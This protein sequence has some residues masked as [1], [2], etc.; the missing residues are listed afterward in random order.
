MIFPFFSLRSHVDFFQGGF[1]SKVTF[2]LFRRRMN[3]RIEAA[4][5]T[6]CIKSVHIVLAN[7]SQPGAFV[8]PVQQAAT[9]PT[10]REWEEHSR[11][12]SR[13]GGGKKS[14]HSE[15]FQKVCERT[16]SILNSL[17]WTQLKGSHSQRWLVHW[18]L[19]KGAFKRKLRC[20][21]PSEE[22]H[23]RW[24]LTR[25]VVWERSAA[26][27]RLRRSPETQRSTDF[28]NTSVPLIFTETLNFAVVCKLG[29]IG[30]SVQAADTAAEE[31]QG[32]KETTVRPSA[33]L[34]LTTA[35]SRLLGDFGLLCDTHTL[36]HT[37]IQVTMLKYICV[38]V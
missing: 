2:G 30:G 20:A 32:T 28:K 5:A 10:H 31:W 14:R 17:R 37:H 1:S 35:W 4:T 23:P 6:W 18:G 15:A 11:C 33:P 34:T 26:L 22:T 38:I 13:F 12:E 21:T 3:Q 8:Q 24:F 36:T 25:M 9:Y 16:L 27:T 19:F 29:Q 7:M